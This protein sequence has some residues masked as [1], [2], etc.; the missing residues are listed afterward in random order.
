MGLLC[1]SNIFN[2]R[3]CGGVMRLRTLSQP[4][5]AAERHEAIIEHNQRIG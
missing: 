4:T 5:H 2:S 1:A 3:E